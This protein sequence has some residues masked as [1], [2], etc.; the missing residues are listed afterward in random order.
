[1]KMCYGSK[2]II[3]H[4]PNYSVSCVHIFAF[5]CSIFF[6]WTFIFFFD[7][8]V[9]QIEQFCRLNIYFSYIFVILSWCSWNYFTPRNK[10]ITHIERKF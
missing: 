1:M 7:F 10:H 3:H 8:A 5:P 2:G 6:I 9:A 4:R